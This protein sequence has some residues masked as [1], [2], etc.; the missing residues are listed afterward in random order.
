MGSASQGA[1]VRSASE[2]LGTHHLSADFSGSSADIPRARHAASVFLSGLAGA[3]PLSSD[4]ALD[5]ILLVVTELV[6][7][8]VRHAPGR[9]TLALTGVVDGV[10]LV[11]RDTSSEPPHPRPAD[12]RS[13]TGGF[14][15]PLAQRLARRLHVE[16]HPD[17]KEIH[18]LLPW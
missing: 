5:D 1:D 7:N 17:G 11:V 13:G 18:A 14:G 15:W 9:F 4:T 6:T 3:V 2:P 16:P 10:H 12:P 8:A